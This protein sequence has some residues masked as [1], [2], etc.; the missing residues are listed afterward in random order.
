MTLMHP[1]PIHVAIVGAGPYGLSIA[2]HLRERAVP[3]RIFG[4]PMRTWLRMPKTLNL[5]SFGFATS[6]SVPR[7]NY[8]FPEYCRARGLEDFDP[9]S[10]E[11]FSQ[12]GLWLQERLVPEVEPVE[13]TG[14]SSVAGAFEV[15]LEGGEKVRAHKV[16]TA[17]GLGYFTRMPEFLRGLPGELASHSSQHSSYESFKGKDV[18]VIGAGSSALEASAVLHEEGARPQVLARGGP[19]LFFDRIKSRRSLLERILVPN[20]VLGQ[21]RLP[22]LL[23]HVPLG[24]RYLPHD[25]RVRFVRTYLG[26]SGAWW[27]RPRVEGKVPIRSHCRVISAV[28][29]EGRVRLRLQEDGN[30]ERTLDVDHVVA[31]TGYEPDVNRL[32]FLDPALRSRLRRIENAPWLSRHFES[33]VPGLDFVGPV[34]AFSSGPLFRFVA[35]VEYTAPALAAHLAHGAGRVL[36][37]GAARSSLA[38]NTG[39]TGP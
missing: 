31:G 26:P 12:Y 5:K 15:S 11:S 22:W 6:L 29:F 9:C 3:F 35:G 34:S 30:R 23:E 2:A 18:A 19:P 1:D 37:G 16:V 38:P 20:S 21:G 39:N 10:M 13:V 32:S 27:L 24:P 14:V 25:R 7:P 36:A 28:P 4:P 8:T 17:V 33:S